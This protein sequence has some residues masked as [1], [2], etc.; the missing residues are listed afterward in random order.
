MRVRAQHGRHAAVQMPAQRLFLGGGLRMN[1]HDDGIRLRLE[2]RHH[3]VRGEKGTLAFQI[4]VGAAQHRE[5]RH[6]ESPR[7]NDHV[8]PTRTGPRQIRR[9]TDPVHLANLVFPAPLVPHVIAQRDGIDPALQQRLRDRTRD[10]GPGRRVF[11]IGDDKIDAPL[12]PQRSQAARDDVAARPAHDVANEQ[13][14]QHSLTV[15][16]PWP[17]AT[18]KSG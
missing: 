16:A 12:G 9:P 13:Q 6:P 14:L 7:L 1:L 10:A 5:H 15:R 3:P 2:L 17:S 11:T 4:H 8:I 18:P